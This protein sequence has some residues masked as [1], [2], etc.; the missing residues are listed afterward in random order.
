MGAEAIKAGYTQVV[1]QAPA[2]MKQRPPISLF[3][4]TTARSIK[5]SRTR[6][7]AVAVHMKGLRCWL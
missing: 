4:T 5:R 3:S 7:S 1:H 2:T 6:E